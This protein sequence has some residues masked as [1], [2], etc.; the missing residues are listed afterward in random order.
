M[1][2]DAATSERCFA[3]SE[4]Y[5]GI[6]VFRVRVSRRGTFGFELSRRTNG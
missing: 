3:I 2:N 1:A 5:A 6:L 4:F